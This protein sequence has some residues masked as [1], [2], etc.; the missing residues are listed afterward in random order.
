MQIPNWR[1]WDGMESTAG[2][3]TVAGVS[4]RYGLV[5]GLSLFCCDDRDLE[6]WQLLLKAI[7]IRSSTQ[8]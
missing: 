2:G 7:T 6:L 3:L 4:G 5:S 1:E 8:K